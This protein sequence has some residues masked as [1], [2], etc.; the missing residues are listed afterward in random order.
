MLKNFQDFQDVMQD[1]TTIGRDLNVDRQARER[2]AV[3]LTTMA[4]NLSQEVQLHSSSVL[5]IIDTVTL[6][7]KIKHIDFA[8]SFITQDPDY[9]V[10]SNVHQEI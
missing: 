8:H 10:S 1:F 9:L 3:D 2:F 4:R 7:A 6:N 5:I